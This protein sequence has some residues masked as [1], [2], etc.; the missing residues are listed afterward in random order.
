M[1]ITHF[2]L[3]Y[4]YFTKKYPAKQIFVLRD[5]CRKEKR[6]KLQVLGN[7]GTGAKIRIGILRIVP[8]DQEPATAPAGVRNAAIRTARI[9][10]K[11]R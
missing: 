2:P 8:V 1:W 4:F 9:I 5:L 10:T 7:C 6:F 11:T 3:V